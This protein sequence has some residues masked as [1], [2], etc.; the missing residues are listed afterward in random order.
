MQ[1]KWLLVT[2]ATMFLVIA[3]KPSQE[4]LPCKY[5]SGGS[6]AAKSET[7]TTEIYVDGT[8]SMRGYVATAGDSR[9]S[10]TLDLLDTIFTLTGSQ[11]SEP[12]VKYYRLGTDPE[13]ITR[14]DYLKTK[15]I[16]FYGGINPKFPELPV[17]QIETAITPINEKAKLTVIITDLYQKDTDITKVSQ[18]IKQHYLNPEQKDQRLAVGILAIR[19]EFQG[20]IFTENNEINRITYNTEEKSSDQYHPFYVIFLGYYSDISYYLGQIESQ[21]GDLTDGSQLL[22]FSPHHLVEAVSELKELPKLP[23]DRDIERTEALHNG[24]AFVEKNN[25]PVD[26]LDVGKSE[27]QEIK[28]NNYNT[29]LTLLPYTLPI[30][31]NDLK[32]NT[33]VK[34]LDRENN[35]FQDPSNAEQLATAVTT[36]DWKLIDNNDTISFSLN[37]QARALQPKEVYFFEIEAIA[38][39]LGEPDWW[40]EWNATSKE[41]RDGSKTYNLLKFLRQLKALTTDKENPPVIGNFCY[42]IQRN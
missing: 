16:E 27:E 10:Q 30:A 33:N 37:I 14:D 34:Q 25:Q 19:S 40:E 23:T 42:A 2:I 22:I 41:I 20:D 38:G 7:L 39:D 36:E 3:C 6:L 29:P 18:K 4:M 32:V 13:E 8:P 24:Q 31:P 35:K 5:E 21:G 12:Q 28:I 15:E 11:S 26:L 17:S 9:Y 1:A